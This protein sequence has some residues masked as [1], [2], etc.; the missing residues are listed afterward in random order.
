[1][2]GPHPINW[3]HK[4]TGLLQ[5]G[6]K[7]TVRQHSHF[8]RNI[9]SSLVL[10]LLIHSAH[11]MLTI[12]HNPMSTFLQITIYVWYVYT[13]ICMVYIIKKISIHTQSHTCT[14]CWL[15]FSRE[16]W[17]THHSAS[18]ST[19]GNCCIYLIHVCV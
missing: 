9:V 16:P 17:I 11:F 19:V 14:F 3:R 8:N 5:A 1:M 6:E 12:F 7:Y 15:Y 10:S 2:D 4:K 13:V 18:P